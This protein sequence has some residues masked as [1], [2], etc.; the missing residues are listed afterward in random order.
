MT[1][2]ETTFTRL[3]DQILGYRRGLGDLIAGGGIWALI[4]LFI[5]WAALEERD[6]LVVGIVSGSIL[7]LGAVGLTLIYGV[8]S[9]ATSPTATR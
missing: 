8:S 3:R 5:V 4:V 1:T 7:A 9:S 2:A 6:A